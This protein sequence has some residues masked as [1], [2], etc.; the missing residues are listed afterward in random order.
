MIYNFESLRFR[1]LQ[2]CMLTNPLPIDKNDYDVI[3]LMRLSHFC[4][5]HDIDINYVLND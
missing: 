5:K 3:T 1:V 4:G 2:L